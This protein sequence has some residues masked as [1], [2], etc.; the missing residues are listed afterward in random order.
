MS[1]ESKK[2]CPYC[3]H[4]ME[5]NLHGLDQNDLEMV[6]EEA[7]YVGSCTYCKVCNP[8][9]EIAS[10]YFLENGKSFFALS[11]LEQKNYIEGRC[12]T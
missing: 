5:N 4:S 2:Q 6:E 8:I 11:P 3:K 12:T 7:V 1:E 10:K 9:L